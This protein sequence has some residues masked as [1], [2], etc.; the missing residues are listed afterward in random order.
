MTENNSNKRGQTRV[1]AKQRIA[2]YSVEDGTL[3]GQ[4]ANFHDKGFMLISNYP[5]REDNIY[6]LRMEFAQAIVGQDRIYLGAECLW[7]RDTSGDQ[8]WAGFSIIDIA[9]ED[10]HLLA[11]L[12]TQLDG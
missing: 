3:V 4:V 12:A 6:R 9:R 1:A 7:V 11:E 10:R 2:A 8:V 5:I